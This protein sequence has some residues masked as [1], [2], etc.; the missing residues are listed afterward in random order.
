MNGM[1]EI[2]KLLLP[3]LLL[4]GTAYGI[5]YKYL[6]YE[7]AKQLVE[8]QK[9]NREMIVPARMQAYE[10]MVLFLERITPEHLLRRVMRP[11]MSARLLH[12]ELLTT[13]RTEYEHNFSQQVYM[14]P[15]AWQM[16]KTATEETIRLIHVC[17]SKTDP[18]AAAGDLARI[19][20]DITTR[21]GKFPT[22]VA[23]DKIK[24][25]F[26]EQFFPPVGKE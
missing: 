5:A 24:K 2:L 16:A 26:A 9:T 22:E 25:E 4:C 15:T 21:A 10:R 12:S 19:M 8:M 14:S 18:T 6:Q 3:A 11:G 20:L 7:A 17:G 1:V 13:V 23:I